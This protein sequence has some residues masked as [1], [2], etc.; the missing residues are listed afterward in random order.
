MIMK[1]TPNQRRIL[2]FLHARESYQYALEQDLGI[3]SGGIAGYLMRM[4]ALGWIEECAP[5]GKENDSRGK[6]YY[7]LTPVGEKILKES[8][9]SIL[10]NMAADGGGP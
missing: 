4:L 3:K 6:K 5:P 1:L 8:K 2:E 10:K 7:R 9:S